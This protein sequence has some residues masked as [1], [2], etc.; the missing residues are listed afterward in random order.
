MQRKFVTVAMGLLFAL[1][2]AGIAAQDQGPVRVRVSESVSQAF[3]YKKVSPEYPPE[4]RKRH[5]EGQVVLKAE[6]SKEGDITSLIVVSGDPVLVPAALDAV[7]LW[8]YRPYLLNGQPASVETQVTVNFV[9]K[10][11]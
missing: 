9:L 8:K 2:G 11:S 6:I 3:L 5:I 4:A 1:S 7:R 10:H